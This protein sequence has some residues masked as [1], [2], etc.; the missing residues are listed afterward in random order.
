M[1]YSLF[2]GLDF[3]LCHLELPVIEAVAHC[4]SG[5]CQARQ[6]LCW[7]LLLSLLFPFLFLLQPKVASLLKILS[8]EKCFWIRGTACLFLLSAWLFP[9]YVRGIPVLMTGYTGCCASGTFLEFAHIGSSV[10]LML[11]SQT[12][13]FCS[14]MPVLSVPACLQMFH[15]TFTIQH[16]QH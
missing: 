13:T 2:H 8:G 9:F 12:R 4:T 11:I 3:I 6:G 1:T 5:V 16:H 15:K 14:G 10:V 7:P